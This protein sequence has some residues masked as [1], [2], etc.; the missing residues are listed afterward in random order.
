LRFIKSEVRKSQ[1]YV[2]NVAQATELELSING[3]KCAILLF[4]KQKTKEPIEIGNATVKIV[5]YRYLGITIDRHLHFGLHVKELHTALQQRLNLLSAA[6]NSNP[7]TK[8]N[9]D[10]KKRGGE[11]REHTS[12]HDNQ[13]LARNTW[14]DMTSTAKFN[15]MEKNSFENQT[16]RWG[17]GRGGNKLS[18]T[19]GAIETGLEGIESAKRNYNDTTLRQNALRK[20]ELKKPTLMVYTDGSINN[21]RKKRRMSVLWSQGLWG[22]IQDRERCANLIGWAEDD[23]NCNELHIPTR[24][25]K[26][27]HTEWLKNGMPN[28]DEGDGRRPIQ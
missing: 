13:K 6:N 26:G 3:Y 9:M 14:Y 19:D 16:P 5:N 4:G 23:R 11:E 21:G 2:I 18:R 17:D 25:T 20:I 24:R 1:F 10:D 12:R 15:L 22:K 27:C 7:R 28:T 8:K